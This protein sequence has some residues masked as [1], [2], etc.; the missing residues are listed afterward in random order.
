MHFFL[1]RSKICHIKQQYFPCFNTNLHVK[2]QLELFCEPGGRF[3]QSEWSYDV[4]S[5]QRPTIPSSKLSVTTAPNTFVAMQSL[6]DY[7]SEDEHCSE[8]CVGNDDSD[9][10]MLEVRN[11]A[12]D[13]DA[14]DNAAG[15][16]IEMKCL[17]VL[18]VCLC[19][20]CCVRSPGFVWRTPGRSLQLHAISA[21]AWFDFFA[22]GAVLIDMTAGRASTETV[23]NTTTSVRN[24]Q[25][26]KESTTPAGKPVSQG[27]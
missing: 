23:T 12:P 10:E 8:E 26:A 5:S 11:S 21:Y 14:V 22:A 27:V 6:W 13:V 19:F 18:C 9:V 3:E 25:T 1:G 15:K 20:S 2:S 24:E 4:S 7:S 16:N 17:S